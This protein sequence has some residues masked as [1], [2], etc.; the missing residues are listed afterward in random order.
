MLA[1]NEAVARALLV[2]EIPTPYRVHDVPSADA[3]ASLLPE[4]ECFGCL[5][6]PARSGLLARE[7]E[8]FQHVLDLIARKPEEELV[9]SLMLRAMKRAVYDPVNTGHFGLGASSYCHFTS[10]IRR[11]PDLLVHRSLKFLLYR[12]LKDARRREM[13]ADMPLVCAHASA[14]ERVA[15]SAAQESQQAKLAEYMQAY[16]GDEFEGII[17][18]VQPFGFF[19]RLKRIAVE[20]LVHVRDLDEGFWTYDDEHLALRPEH[21]G[22]GFRLGQE[23]RVRVRSASPLRGQIDFSL[24]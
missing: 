1:A 11:Y 16:V 13:E 2:S 14:M 6:G 20:G 23:V 17:V 21:G 15:A 10:P 9:S 19:V 24:V 4:L 3:C 22:D 12:N 8:G 5:D 18:S 7:P